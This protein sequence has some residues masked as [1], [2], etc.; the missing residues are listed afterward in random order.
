MYKYISLHIQ[1]YCIFICVSIHVYLYIL[2]IHVYLYIFPLLTKSCQIQSIFSFF[3]GTKEYIK[4]IPGSSNHMTW[5]KLTK[6]PLHHEWYIKSECQSMAVTYV[7]CILNV[8]H[9]YA[10]YLYKLECINIKLN[11]LN[12]YYCIINS[13]KSNSMYMTKNMIFS[14]QTCIW[15]YT[16]DWTFKSENAMVPYKQG[17]D[18]NQSLELAPKLW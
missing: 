11:M 1:L 17:T 6:G 3:W 8:C 12:M 14:Y 16:L 18:N 5:L 9:M 2:S 10:K 4:C 7:A 13:W 15:S